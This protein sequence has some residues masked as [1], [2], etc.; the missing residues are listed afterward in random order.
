MRALTAVQAAA[1]FG[2]A[3]SVLAES[4]LSYLGLG[5]PPPTPSWGSM[6]S[7]GQA[8]Y[9]LAPRLIFLPGTLILLTVLGF[10]LLGEG[11]RDVL[12]PRD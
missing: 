9:R 2:V 4:V 5:V 8:W 6:I 12:D 3:G 1:I 7:E 10:N 11:L